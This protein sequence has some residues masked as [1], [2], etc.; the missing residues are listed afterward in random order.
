MLKGLQDHPDRA[1]IVAEL[2]ARPFET[3]S[4]PLRASHIAMLSGSAAADRDHVARLCEAL[5][6]RVPLAQ[7]THHSVELGAFR[8]R[9]ERHTEFSTYTFF[10]G[11]QSAHEAAPFDAVALDKVPEEWLSAL[12]GRLIAGAHLV[13]EAASRPA[14]S[15]HE[16][17]ELFRTPNVAGS[18]VADGCALV[19][20]DFRLHGDGLGRILVQD[21]GLSPM[22][23][24]R[25]VQRLLEIE[26]YRLLALL[27]FPLAR[28]ASPELS[29]LE[30]RLQAITERM[31]HESALEDQQTLLGEI[32]GLAG[33]L[34][35]AAAARNFRLSAARA[36][37]SIVRHRIDNLREQRLTGLQTIGEFMDRRFTPAMQTCESVSE[38]QETLSR[39]LS[40]AADL[41]RTGVDVALEGQNRDLLASMNRRT[42]LQ[43]RLQQTVEGLSVVVIS[44]YSAGL[45]SYLLKGIVAGGQP[46][47]VDL[48]L[49]L[50]V[51]VIVLTI[52]YAI[53]SQRRRLMRQPPQ[54]G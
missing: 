50:S 34:A 15:V 43:L 26:T 29:A 38:R 53:R 24:G 31:T 1:Q 36:Y 25:L 49:G 12:P 2:H 21:R 35:Q 20:T 17:V 8:L 19:F 51:P 4:A 45:L 14:R 27:A 13:L 40:R 42:D 44:Y 37:H 11:D 23:S 28:G 6:Q 47:N 52:W 54:D 5:E 18:A 48:I 3:L 7:A 33:E 10:I 39:S 46:L 32:S 22:R 41:L 9:W 16:I 30:Q